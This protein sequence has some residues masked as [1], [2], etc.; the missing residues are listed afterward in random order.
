MKVF[1]EDLQME[2]TTK[3][4][5]HFTYQTKKASES[6]TSIRKLGKY[7]SNYVVEVNVST[8]L[9]LGW[10]RLPDLV[11]EQ[12]QKSFLMNGNPF[13]EM[14]ICKASISWLPKEARDEI[15]RLYN[16]IIKRRAELCIAD[17]FM[18]VKVFGEF[19]HDF[20][21]VKKELFRVRDQVIA[22]WDAIKAAYEAGVKNLF[23]H[24]KMTP[25]EKEYAIKALLAAVP[26]KGQ[27]KKAFSVEMEVCAFPI[28]P[29]G[30]FSST[31]SVARKVCKAWENKVV[32][33]TILAV[34]NSVNEGWERLNAGMRQCRCNRAVLPSTIDTLIRY[35]KTLSFKNVFQNKLLTDLETGLLELPNL[36][37]KE[38]ENRIRDGVIMVYR[39]AKSVPINLNMEVSA[40][41]D[42][43][44][45]AMISDNPM[46]YQDFLARATK[47]I[48]STSKSRKKSGVVHEPK[49]SDRPTQTSVTVRIAKKSGREVPILPTSGR[50]TGR[51]PSLV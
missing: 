28:E 47:E 46:V 11:H 29:S 2:G 15:G 18:P 37:Q 27:Y 39:Y 4:L 38:Q 9:Q 31:P 49:V 34:V 26:E 7:I 16:S 40:Y 33:T 3:L 8:S 36:T 35:A 5:N 22:N 12:T 32:N 30:F 44:L 45:D 41:S 1:K 23:K 20:D 51:R 14:H 25:A 13:Y 42:K 10:T 21:Q 50:R 19:K 48:R 24:T 17:N 43:E 6:N